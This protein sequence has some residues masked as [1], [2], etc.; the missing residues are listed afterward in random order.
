[1][2]KEDSLVENLK[3]QIEKLEAIIKEKDKQ[4]FEL[5]KTPKTVNNNITV[6]QS[7]NTFGKEKID[8]INPKQIQALLADP[9][10][11]VHK[12]S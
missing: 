4:M 3:Q 6:D 1:M 8:H 5:A 10:S 11:A 12:C 2:V 9:A 7:V